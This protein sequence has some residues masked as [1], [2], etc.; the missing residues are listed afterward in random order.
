[1]KSRYEINDCQYLNKINFLKW[2]IMDLHGNLKWKINE[3]QLVTKSLFNQTISLKSLKTLPNIDH[4]RMETFQ[5]CES[6][7]KSRFY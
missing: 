3:Y 4:N 2:L 5:N 6:K 1:M 7:K